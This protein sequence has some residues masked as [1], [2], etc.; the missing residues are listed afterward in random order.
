MSIK[1]GISIGI[2]I[3]VLAIAVALGFRSQFSRSGS[4][5]NSFETAGPTSRT[6][7]RTFENLAKQVERSVVD[8]VTE[9]ATTN[10]PLW[11][12]PFWGH[13]R[14]RSYAELKQKNLG[15]GFIVSSSG[16]ILTNSHIV[17]SASRIKVKLNDNRILDAV[18]VGSDPKSDLAVLKIGA[19]NLPALRFAPSNSVKVG[20]WVAA[21]GSP[22]GL[23]KTVTAGIISA[24]GRATDTG[25]ALIQT[26][27]AINSGNSGG[28]LVAL[29]GEVVGVNT[30]VRGPDRDFDG[31]GFAIPSDAAQRI[32]NELMKSGGTKRG[33][34]GV[35]IQEVAPEIANNL[36]LPENVG[37]LITE[38]APDGP[39]LKAGLQPGDIIVE[40]NH[41]LVRTPHEFNAAV[42]DT[43]IGKPIPMKII[44][45]G[46]E[47]V[48][49]VLVG[50]RPSSIAERFHSPDASNRGRLG[51]TVENVTPEIQLYFHLTS[52]EG[53]IVVEVA[54]RSS[55]EG[56][57][58]QPGDVIHQINRLPV[59][60]ANDLIA[61]L[62]NLSDGSTVLLGIERQGSRLYLSLQ[63]E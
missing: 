22:F 63:L 48:Y 26:D 4:Y 5:E 32:Y 11:P 58:V 34:L 16:Y 49:N 59:H 42:M 20:E 23:D 37:A 2:G 27:A 57:G 14:N 15:S 29:N 39:A 56:G 53:V 54:Q 60:G 24:K 52:R 41:Q 45:D 55:A 36:R 50:E 3:L 12:D 40:Y 13:F 21:F 44:R 33:W 47:F 25:L 9:Q 28:P 43:R 38:L 8:I 46:K 51:I 10:S 31:I 62:H 19:D 7:H 35:R 30:D 17:E 61:A 6:P 18:V 1:S